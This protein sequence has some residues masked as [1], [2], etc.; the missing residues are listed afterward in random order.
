M[1]ERVLFVEQNYSLLESTMVKFKDLVNIPV[2]ENNESFV[3]IRSSGDGLIG[4]YKELS[5]MSSDFP[6]ICVRH[7]VMD[8]LIE[9]DKFIRDKD[10]SL[11]LMV[12]YGYRSLEIQEKYFNEK[13]EIK[14]QE[15]IPIGSS[16]DEEVHRLIAVPSVA[17]HPTGGAV[18]VTIVDINSGTQIDLGS[19]LYDFDTRDSYTFSP[20]INQEGKNNRM[21]LRKAMMDQGFAPYD[22]EWWHFSYGDKEWAFYY[23]QPCAIYEQ[24]TIR[25]VS[26]T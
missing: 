16:I 25:E 19:R 10:P 11:R 2:V 17:G 23:N 18:D 22:G 21:L 7:S 26:F 6:E 4:Q 12:T 1:K 20:Y 8:K 14:S 13:K 9:A 15:P 5:D 3:F 24:K